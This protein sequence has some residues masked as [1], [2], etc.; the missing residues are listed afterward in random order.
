MKVALESS[1][2][3]FKNYT[4]I[5]FYI[6]NLFDAMH[7]LKGVS[8]TLTFRLKKKFS[9]HNDF[10]KQLLNK[11]HVW[12]FGNQLLS[13]SKFDV[14]HS[15]HTPFLNL[16]KTLKVATV[17]DLAVHLPQ[18]NDFD[19]ATEYFKKKRMSLFQIFTK[20]ADVIITVSETTKRDFLEFF[21]F[22]QERIH[23]VPLAPSF[24]LSDNEEHQ[25]SE[26]LKKLD[27]KAQSYF[28]SMGGVSLRKNTFNLIKAY[29]LSKS[30][31]DFKLVITG[32]IEAEHEEEIR[33]YINTNQLESKIILTK[34]LSNHDLQQIYLNAKAFLFPTF[35]EGFGIPILEAM[36]AELPV[37]TS[38][39]GAAPETAGGFAVLTDPFNPESI[40]EGIDK[41]KHI[42]QEHLK[43]AK[44][45]AL[46]HTW[47]KTAK[48]T[49]NVYKKYM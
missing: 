22:P 46:A 2:L 37:L 33:N 21:D 3:F 9:S 31:A 45:Y 20:K 49:T 29:H 11:K 47:A 1:S 14:S 4:G 48:M 12:H 32:K 24:D 35:Y 44:A 26:I 27:L 36:S 23:V 41:L 42:N 16:P 8:P 7:N 6:Y 10:H 18:F 30:K 38:T 43:R 34:Y 5:P 17:H 19:F 15:L 13:T 25:P 39:T 40:A 28:I